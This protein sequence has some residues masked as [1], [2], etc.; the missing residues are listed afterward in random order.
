MTRTI[1]PLEYLKALADWVRDYPGRPPMTWA[2]V[3][4]ASLEYARRDSSWRDE[5]RLL[6]LRDR[7]ARVLDRVRDE[8]GMPRLDSDLAAA[9]RRLEDYERGRSLPDARLHERFLRFL[10][11]RP[12]PTGDWTVGAWEAAVKYEGLSPEHF[13]GRKR[14]SPLAAAPPADD[15]KGWADELDA[16]VGLRSVKEAVRELRDFLDIERLRSSIGL[17]KNDF[18]LHQAFLGNPGTGKTSVARILARIYREF[19]FLEKGHIL[20]VDRSG[21]VGGYLGHTEEKTEQAVHAALGGVLFIDEAYSLAGKG[22]DDFG[23]IAIDTLVKRMEDY[24]TQFVVIAAGYPDEMK[25]LFDSNPGLYDRI[26]TILTFHDYDDDELQEIFRRF[27]DSGRY[28]LDES[29]LTAAREHLRARRET[30]G[31]VKFG[32]AR[33]ARTLWEATLRRQSRRLIDRRGP[34]GDIDAG[35]LSQVMARDIPPAAHA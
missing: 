12:A 27:A 3:V 18:Q 33:A 9:A 32:N 24:R 31:T 15:G 28:T 34:G 4:F 35:E 14:W 19:G 11:D 13:D 23:Q 21:L 22:K 8:P 26:G 17:P 2:H 30:A 1:S 25:R 10:A 29:V 16:L 20:E 5:P 6:A 7:M